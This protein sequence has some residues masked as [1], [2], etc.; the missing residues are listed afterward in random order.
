MQLRSHLDALEMKK[1]YGLNPMAPEFVPKV[2]RGGHSTRSSGSAFSSSLIMSAQQYGLPPFYLPPPS[3][4]AA[5]ATAN[6]PPFPPP[7]APPFYQHRMNPCSPHR[8]SQLNHSQAA[9]PHK[10]RPRILPFNKSSNFSPS[11]L[12]GPNMPPPIMNH[13][14]G[15]LGTPPNS[16]LSQ[17]N[18][19]F[20]VSHLS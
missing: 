17:L 8:Q 11:H 12:S 7:P 14:L 5:V 4:T 13:S 19:P 10:P 16:T 20:Q 6:I 3:S 2:I 18:S 9:H 1:L 15:N